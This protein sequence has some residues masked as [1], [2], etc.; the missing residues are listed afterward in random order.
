MKLALSIKSLNRKHIFEA[1]WFLL[2]FFKRYFGSAVEVVDQDEISCSY[3]ILRFSLLGSVERLENDGEGGVILYVPIKKVFR[4]LIRSVFQI[5][6]PQSNTI[7]LFEYFV[8]LIRVCFLEP[9]EADFAKKG[10]F[11]VHGA[12]LTKSHT[13]S[14]MLVAPSKGGKS[15][16]S[17]V[18]EEVGYRVVSDNYVF[19]DG[20]RVITVPE[21]R[22]FGSAKRFSFSFYGK[23]V[24]AAPVEMTL[25][26]KKIMWLSFSNEFDIQR[27]ASDDLSTMLSRLYFNECE[28]V[29]VDDKCLVERNFEKIKQNLDE[30]EAFK[31]YMIRD[32]A[33]T[34]SFLLECI[35]D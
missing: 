25:E 13:D 27:I 8:F 28:G 11:L 29:F 18:L 35:D 24:H 34:R 32:I 4:A 1:P 6:F 23:H 7:G 19:F 12:L 31:F 33:K 14:L 15:T 16:I 2:S 3:T 30:I 17:K 5:S 9:L 20:K 10:F 22:R 26:V 21:C